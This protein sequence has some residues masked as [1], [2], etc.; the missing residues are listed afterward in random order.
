MRVAAAR[1]RGLTLTVLSLALTTCGGDSSEPA[2]PSNSGPDNTVASITV[3][4]SSASIA[5]GSTAQF[6]AQARNASG[7]V[8]S[9]VSFTWSSSDTTVATI[10]G[11]G[12]ATAGSAGTT[13]IAA[14]ASGVSGAASVTVTEPAPRL[15]GFNFSLAQGYYWDFYWSYEYNSVS[16]SGA[17][18]HSVKGG[19][20]RITLG[21][22]ITVQGVQVF[23]L[24]MSGDHD[25]GDWDYTPRWR[26]LGIDQD[27]IVGSQDGQTLEVVFDAMNG[28]WTG[29]G[30]W[31]EYTSET[32]VTASAATLDN[33]FIT[34]D[35]VAVQRSA[36]QDFCETIAG[37]TVCPNDQA[38]TFSESEYYKG[39]IGPIGLYSYSAYSFN[40][41]G[42]YD[43]FSH[44]RHVGLVASSLPGAAGVVPTSPPW[45]TRS[46]MPTARANAAAAVINGKIYVL[47][48][49][50]RTES[51]TTVLASVD[52][53]DPVADN[54]TS[55]AP[56]PAPRTGHTATVL[57]GRIYVLG[58]H[59]GSGGGK[60][61]VWEYDPSSNSWTVRTATTLVLDG[62]SAVAMAP[63]ILVYPAQ[64]EEAYAYEVGADTWWAITSA[65]VRY[66]GHASV[67][68]GPSVYLVGGSY[69]DL[70][71]GGYYTKY[72]G[73]N[74]EFDA[75]ESYGSPNAWTYHASMPTGRAE[76]ALAVV[77]GEI[78]AIG[79]TNAD[80]PS[81]AVEKYDPASDTWTQRFPLL[82][83]TKDHVA[84]VV[85]NKVYVIGGSGYWDSF[86][87]VLEYD[88]ANEW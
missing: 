53:Y 13:S 7:T 19:Y 83:G 26:Y 69:Q 56:M 30:F 1:F 31:A 35:A 78:F 74:L 75:E 60:D 24:L 5:A 66:A 46:P 86:T 64:I 51:A 67:A 88:P 15:S 3:S 50:L 80:G 14:T 6:Q 48:G 33:E 36:G 10:S 73:A 87:T 77:D 16:G 49:E 25:D 54:W 59:D 70:G 34:T 12:L 72:T 62:H 42:Y 22:P 81:R 43:S 17:G 40:G 18:V 11:T 85:N 55:T 47:G 37:H 71:I 79:G 84:A 39:G 52:V 57:G 63:Y 45:T 58:G 20:F 44:L 23:E 27:K 68:V 38:W 76:L 28:E 21:S 4:P 41:G 61:N 65:P 29:G 8:L 9:G 32:Q 2:G 82:S